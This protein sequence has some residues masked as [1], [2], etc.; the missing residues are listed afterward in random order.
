MLESLQSPWLSAGETVVFFG[1]SLTSANPGYVHNLIDRLAA[2]GIKGIKA[3][4]GGDK[5]P[6]ALTRLDS[7]V[8]VH[9]P[10]AVSIFLGAND[11]A[12]GRGIWADEPIVSPEAF[13]DNLQW[14]INLL[15]L[16]YEVK[17]FCIA[18]PLWRF[19][20]ATYDMH[21]DILYA[22]RMMARDAADNMRALLVP[23]DTMWEAA[24]LANESRRD[25]ATGLLFTKDGTHPTEE[26]YQMIADTFWKYWKMDQ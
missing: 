21:G 16:R 11:A 1:D 3:G 6:S 5:T 17:K 18:T 19:E 20:G 10:D 25:P 8:G 9:K 26:G 12:V 2:R 23:L 24:T 4:L 7:A 22:Y 13:R 14:M 15:R